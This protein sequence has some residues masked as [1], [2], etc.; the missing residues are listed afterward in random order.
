MNINDIFA[1]LDVVLGSD[2]DEDVESMTPAERLEQTRR[3][4]GAEYEKRADEIADHFG[5]MAKEAAGSI[6]AT[7]LLFQ[8][9][10]HAARATAATI[11][12]E[13]AYQDLLARADE[14]IQAYGKSAESEVF[15]VTFEIVAPDRLFNINLNPVPCTH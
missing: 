2:I 5:G 13:L 4:I 9:S 12:L 15:R 10:M 8:A 7:H 6:G 14:L 1:A 11:A 3:E